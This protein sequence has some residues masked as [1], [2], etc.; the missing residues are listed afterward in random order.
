M[1]HMAQCGTRIYGA[2]FPPGRVSSYRKEKKL[3]AHILATCSA[4]L[5]Q[6]FWSRV[7]ELSRLTLKRTWMFCISWPLPASP[8]WMSF[9][10][11]VTWHGTGCLMCRQLYQSQDASIAGMG[12]SWV[13]VGI[14][15][16][17][18]YWGISH[19]VCSWHCRKINALKS[20]FLSANPIRVCWRSLGTSNRERR[21]RNY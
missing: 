3:F 20:Y 9:N 19:L 6:V 5:L 14:F 10:L 16:R 17:F 21:S 13:N 8:A 4:S 2:G 11:R 1:W 18:R 12:F 15:R 7:T